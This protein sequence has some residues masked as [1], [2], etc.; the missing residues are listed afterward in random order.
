MGI[1]WWVFVLFINYTYIAI[2]VCI[3]IF[4]YLKTKDKLEKKRALILVSA[5]LFPLVGNIIH[6]F[7]TRPGIIEIPY[8]LSSML[9]A[10]SNILFFIGFFR[11]GLF[12][13]KS[14][15]TEELM[16]NINSG[17]VII[18][19]NNIIVD[20]NPVL[21]KMVNNKS[22]DIIGKN[23]NKINS[24]LFKNNKNKINILIKSVIKNPK[25]FLEDHLEIKKPSEKYF[26][27]VCSS[28]KDKNDNVLGTLLILEDITES[29]MYQKKIERYNKILTSERERLIKLTN[30]LE[31]SRKSL[32]NITE[33]FKD[34]RDEV[35]KANKKLKKVDEMRKEFVSHT[36]HELRTPLGVFRWSLEMLKN[37][38]VGKINQDQR[39]LL[40]N[41]TQANKR[42]I[43]LVNNLLEI[44]RMDQGRFKVN[45]TSCDL[46][47]LIVQALG[48]L[49]NR[50]NQKKLEIKWKKSKLK[51]P[52]VKADCERIIQIL[53]NIINN[54]VKYTPA[55]GII[56]I[57]LK[58]TDEIA[59]K[60]VIKK[61]K[62]VQKNKKYLLCSV[63][64]TG[65]G[66]PEKEQEKM[67]SRFFRAS[68]A[69]KS[70]IEGTGLGMAV[71]KSIVNMHSGAIWFESIEEKGTTIYFTIP[72]AE[73][74]DKQD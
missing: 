69:V 41:I 25:I 57:K 62:Y 53:I 50:I 71:T 65:I 31:I 27:I 45:I 17:I 52:D 59:P 60:E 56:T 73:D 26:S 16:R 15:V 9:F 29:H 30:D 44:S 46:S 34:V 40:E 64:D 6:I 42:L 19:L 2:G 37:E 4:K 13:I 74:K 63:A 18:D 51:F 1:L 10:F 12:D 33:D 22:S 11:Y 7:I 32:M 49:S 3:Y 47:D 39:E 68:N 36:A 24:L 21:V 43:N 35:T 38:D 54:S 67:F 28:I 61:Y 66:I 70:E 8:D 5:S 58:E 14:F 55:G 72:V 23:I 48:E 20:I